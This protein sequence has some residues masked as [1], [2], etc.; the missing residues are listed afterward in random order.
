MNCSMPRVCVQVRTIFR[1]R[2]GSR[3]LVLIVYQHAKRLYWNRERYYRLSKKHGKSVDELF[4][5]DVVVSTINIF[6]FLPADVAQSGMFASSKQR[7]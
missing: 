6:G 7:L 4:R 3:Q 5:D 1:I 2:I